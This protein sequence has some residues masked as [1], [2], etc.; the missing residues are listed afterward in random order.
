MRWA[1]ES[2]RAGAQVNLLSEIGIETFYSIP[3]L[4]KG[5]TEGRFWLDGV[6]GPGVARPRTPG[7]ARKIGESV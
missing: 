3:R 1:I 4:K 6:T 5:E 2:T 7:I